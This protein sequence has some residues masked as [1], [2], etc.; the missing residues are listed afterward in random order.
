VTVLLA[1]ASA[2]AYGV[3]DFTAGMCSRRASFVQVGVLTQAAAVLVVVSALGVTGHAPAPFRS[4]AWGGAS[5]VGGAVGTLALYRGLGRARIGV[6]AP[7]SAV[8]AAALPVLVGL[9]MGERP[10][11]LALA[12]VGCAIPAVWLVARSAGPA[13]TGPD[14]APRGVLDGLVAGAGFGLLFIGL[15]RAG[16]GHGLWP[17]AAGQV[18]SLALLAV[19]TLVRRAGGLPDRSVVAGSAVSGVLA[20]A[21]VILYFFSTSHGLLAVVAVLAS[22]YPGVTVLLARVALGERMGRGQKAGLGLAAL[23]IVLIVLGG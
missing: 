21:A 10:V 16:T 11:A 13:K 12:G 5:G 9:V 2:V 3:S 8:G 17:V 20:A 19:A 18:V 23:A 1:L 22:L 15:Q 7:M 14:P 6:V 4:L